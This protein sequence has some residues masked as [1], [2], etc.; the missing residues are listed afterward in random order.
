VSKNNGWAS[1]LAEAKR[2]AQIDVTGPSGTQYTIR[3]LTLD[4]LAS[5]DGLPDDL[6]RAAL[7]EMVPGGLVMEIS[8][9]LRLGDP[10]SLQAARKLSEDTVRLRDRIVLK[11]IVAPAIREKDL[12][13]LD[14]FDKAMIAAIAQ[15]KLSEDATGKQV[16]ADPL[17]TFREVSP[18][19]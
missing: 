16:G 17:A 14:P 12:A 15:R 11:S 6:L 4:E 13:A 9:K 10:E 18:Q 7:L 8:E 2:N 19:Q 1:S 5:E 3:P